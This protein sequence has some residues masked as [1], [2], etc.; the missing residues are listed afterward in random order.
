MGDNMIMYVLNCLLV[1][2]KF[3]WLFSFTLAITIGW[4]KT[5]YTVNEG[6]GQ[7]IVKAR[8]TGQSEAVIQQNSIITLDGTALHNIGIFLCVCVYVGCVFECA[9][10]CVCVCVC[11][12]EKDGDRNS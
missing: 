2:L 7:L 6:D 9:C 10:V 4:E 11:W 3:M 12:T 8:L 1:I 5:S